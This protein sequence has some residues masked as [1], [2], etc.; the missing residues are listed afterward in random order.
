MTKLEKPIVFWEF[1]YPKNIENDILS[2]KKLDFVALS[3]NG[4]A[5]GI[6]I[7]AENEEEI[8]ELRQQI[9]ELIVPQTLA[10]IADVDDLGF[11]RVHK[12]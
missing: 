1:C 8:L 10:V 12:F 4:L 6:T 9:G 2:D 7:I 3:K 5:L 11:P